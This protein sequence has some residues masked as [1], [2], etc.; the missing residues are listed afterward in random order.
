MFI[1]KL[2]SPRHQSE[3]R[4]YSKSS[5]F[6]KIEKYTQK[7]LLQQTTK[8]VRRLAAGIFGSPFLVRVLVDKVEMCFFF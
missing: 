4:E 3:A 7:Y 6:M 2:L 8:W 5:A 1:C